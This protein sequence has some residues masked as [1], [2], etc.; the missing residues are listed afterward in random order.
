[1][2]PDLVVVGTNGAASGFRLERTRGFGALG[3]G[4][5]VLL[6]VGTGLRWSTEMLSN[7]VPRLTV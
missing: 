6:S 4:C 5:I 7:L 3:G 2:R 1:M